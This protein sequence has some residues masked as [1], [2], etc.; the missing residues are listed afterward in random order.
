MK[1]SWS[2][3][4]ILVLWICELTSAGCSRDINAEKQKFFESGNQY[5]KQ[6]KYAEAVIQYQNAIQRDG[7]FAP[8]H[9]QLAKCYVGEKLWPL[10]FRE[11]TVTL[12]IDPK[13]LDGE[14]ELAN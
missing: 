1:R 11:L 8:A 13:N 2:G 14:L 7:T 6:G 12:Q 9:Y 5:L 3:K 4:A 10:A